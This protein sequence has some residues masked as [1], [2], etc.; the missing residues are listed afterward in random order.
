[1]C[2]IY[3]HTPTRPKPEAADAHLS[4]FGHTVTTNC[5]V[6]SREWAFNCCLL[7][8]WD[9]CA[10]GWTP[11][12]LDH[13]GWFT[14]RAVCTVSAHIVWQIFAICTCGWYCSSRP[15]YMW[16]HIWFPL[17]GCMTQT[18]D[19]TRALPLFNGNRLLH[20]GH[21]AGGYIGIANPNLLDRSGQPGA[22]A[23][24]CI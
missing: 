24:D 15:G 13:F 7:M 18:A 12:Q 8:L 5:V 1:M 16:I 6:H 2:T 3:E 14:Q 20:G 23:V 11:Q 10:H 9:T 22:N 17:W 4:H 19:R 21:L